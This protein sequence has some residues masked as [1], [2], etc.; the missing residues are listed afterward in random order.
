[1]AFNVA[2]AKKAGYS[3]QEIQ[4]F[5]SGDQ[6]GGLSK[7]GQ[8]TV[9]KLPPALQALLGVSQ[10]ASNAA[11][12]VGLGAVPDLLSQQPVMQQLQK[13]SGINPFADQTNINQM[14]ANPLLRAGQDAAGAASWAVPGMSIGNGLVGKVAGNALQGGISGGLGAL[15]QG[16]NPVQ[17]AV[18]GAV[19]N[20]LLSGAG[21][22][23]TDVLPRYIGLRNFGPA[24]LSLPEVTRAED[25]LGKDLGGVRNSI[26][27]Q[28]P[29]FES[30]AGINST[31]GPATDVAAAGGLSEPARY[32]YSGAVRDPSQLGEAANAK[33][34]TNKRFD[35]YD[36]I[37]DLAKEPAWIGTPGLEDLKKT[38]AKA[39]ATKTGKLNDIQKAILD[40]DTPFDAWSR[41]SNKAYA[42]GNTEADI[43]LA[44]FMK[45]ASHVAREN[46]INSS[47][48][49]E[50]T[51]RIMDLYAA[52][53]TMN[54]GGA[55]NNIGAAALKAAKG[56]L[57]EL[58][59]A[60]LAALI[61][62]LQGLTVPALIDTALTNAVTGPPIARGLVRG[63]VGLAKS[64]GADILRVL[65]LQGAQNV[66][67]GLNSGQ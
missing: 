20:P 18:Q 60:G 55:N 41:L 52:Q 35:L 36:K 58:G 26:L 51:R 67:N 34:D 66:V 61:P 4:S 16:Q 19:V 48:D 15:A 56:G 30:G 63:G 42:K 59:G 12:S 57:G 54:K 11:R 10:G 45:S 1:M 24:G 25:S 50:S 29:G 28:I 6:F 7:Q 13:G 33:L 17:G 37:T 43:K 22:A 39:F 38:S 64:G 9:A 8:Q 5:L 53:T 62:G 49:P 23:L 2:A 21:A 3:D 44:N 47:K 31:V 46:V 27:S 14:Q 32:G 65:G 40:S